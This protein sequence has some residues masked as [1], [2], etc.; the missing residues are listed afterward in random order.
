MRIPG[1]EVSGKGHEIG[2]L[3]R[4]FPLLYRDQVLLLVRVHLVPDPAGAVEGGAHVRLEGRP[5]RKFT[6]RG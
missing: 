3:R 4:K 1:P 2:A 5:V 6:T